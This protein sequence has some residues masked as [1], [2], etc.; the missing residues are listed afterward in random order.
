MVNGR[1][2]D[3]ETM[4]EIGNYD[5]PRTKFYWEQNKYSSNFEYHQLARSFMRPTCGCFGMHWCGVSILLV[6]WWLEG[7][8]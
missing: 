4:N 8:L 5:I 6:L 1:L 2:Y 3:S 7:R